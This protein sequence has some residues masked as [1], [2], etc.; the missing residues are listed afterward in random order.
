[1]EAYSDNDIQQH[2]FH[3]L[4]LLAMMNMAGG[5]SGP[6]ATPGSVG[7]IAPSHLFEP[8]LYAILIR[9]PG[10]MVMQAAAHTRRARRR[11]WRR[12]RRTELFV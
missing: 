5:Y 8:S 1:M 7:E 4:L 2:V 3:D 11:A 6:T 10:T 12:W 9:H